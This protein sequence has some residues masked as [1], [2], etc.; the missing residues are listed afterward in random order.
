VNKPQCLTA[1]RWSSTI[2]T[3]PAVRV[4]GRSRPSV[5]VDVVG[6]SWFR[7]QIGPIRKA[8]HAWSSRAST[9][10]FVAGCAPARSLAVD[11]ADFSF[12]TASIARHGMHRRTAQYEPPR[13]PFGAAQ[14]DLDHLSLVRARW[15]VPAGWL[16]ATTAT[17]RLAPGPSR[18][19]ARTSHELA[20][21]LSTITRRA[22]GSGGQPRRAL[23]VAV[24]APHTL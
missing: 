23:S 8:R 24:R 3:Y 4:R 13:A 1:T 5:A 14:P 19:A 20:V 12:A 21:A 2:S 11:F 7:T 16:A 22:D 18:P 6:G 9:P 17:S 10:G 15:L